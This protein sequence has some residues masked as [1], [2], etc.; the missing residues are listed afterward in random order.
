MEIFLDKRNLF[1]Q[2][3]EYLELG[4]TEDIVGFGVWSAC[5]NNVSSHSSKKPPHLTVDYPGKSITS[6]VTLGMSD[7]FWDE[8]Q[9]K[10][11]FLV[12]EIGSVTNDK[13]AMKN[14][15]ELKK[16]RWT[17]SRRVLGK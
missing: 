10:S 11:D 13:Y 8:V 2:Q 1:F 9:Q 6:D 16:R 15:T 7:H 3:L 17:K 12:R 4:T 14:K 5:R